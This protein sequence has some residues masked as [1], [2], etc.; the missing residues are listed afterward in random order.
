MRKQYNLAVLPVRGGMITM[1]A[2]AVSSGLA[3]LESELEKVDSSL[4]EPPDQHDLSAEVSMSIKIQDQLRGAVTSR[5]IED[6]YNTGIRLDYDKYMDINTY[7]GQSAYGTTGLHNTIQG[8]NAMMNNN[9]IQILGEN[10]SFETH[11]YTFGGIADTYDRFMMDVAGAAETPVTKLFGRSPAG[12][13]ATGESDM[14]NYYDVIEEKQESILRPIYDKLLPIMAMSALGAV[15]DDLDFEFNAVRRPDE[16]EMSDLAS[17]N[18]DSVTKA[19][20]AGLIFQRTALKELRSQSEITGM[21]TNITDEDIEKADDTIQDPNEG[22]GD[23][24]DMFGG[25]GHEGKDGP[26]ATGNGPRNG[27]K[28]EQ[29]KLPMQEEKQPSNPFQAMK[30]KE[31]EPKGT[32]DSF[33]EAKHPRG[34]DPVN[35]GRFSKADGGENSLIKGKNDGNVRRKINRNPRTIRLSKQEYAR[36]VSELNTNLSKEERKEKIL[37]KGIGNYVYVIINKGF[38]DYQI[39]GREE[40]K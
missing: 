23:L 9:S 24:G 5:S 12:M 28:T 30:G 6:M 16:D 34:G 15:P 1:D 25:G 26:V 40:L 32:T 8:M 31:P 39:I 38:N 11:Q 36:I 7:K 14:Q 3:F 13:N 35:R 2:S 17:K 33:N 22:M 19:F 4:R 10:D 18:T 37:F 21:W 20:Q 27:E 29:D